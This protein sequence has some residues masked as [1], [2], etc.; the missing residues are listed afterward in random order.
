MADAKA[1]G[2][3][4]CEVVRTAPG[5]P[6]RTIFYGTEPRRDGAGFRAIAPDRMVAH[7]DA[8]SDDPGDA[9]QFADWSLDG[10]VDPRGTVR[11]PAH[12]V[13]HAIGT[14]PARDPL[15][16]VTVRSLKVNAPIGR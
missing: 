6:D 7:P 14:D 3:R 10:T 1:T 11:V 15:L 13:V 8:A 5:E 9:Y 16:R 12:V 4:W 2:G